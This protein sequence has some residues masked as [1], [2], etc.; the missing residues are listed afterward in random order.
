MS[1]DQ[2]KTLKLISNS[3]ILSFIKMLRLDIDLDDIDDSQIEILTEEQISIEPSL[4]R[5][6]FI[7]RIRDII[8]MLEYQSTY[9]R[10]KDKKR[11]TVYISNF[12]F[13]NNAENLK[14]IFAVISTAQES[15]IIEY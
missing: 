5:P 12:D 2:D 3:H 4:Y 1:Q 8:L 11:F 15:K 7:I 14:I 13:K 6:D 9:L 10:T